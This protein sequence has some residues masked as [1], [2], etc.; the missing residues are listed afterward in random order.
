M[1][2]L[3]SHNVML[4][5]FE[6]EHLKKRNWAIR[7]RGIAISRLKIWGF[8]MDFMLGEIQTSLDLRGPILRPHANFQQNPI[9]RG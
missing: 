3:D 4:L 8:S 7:G 1:H 2:V 5:H 6:T 9:I